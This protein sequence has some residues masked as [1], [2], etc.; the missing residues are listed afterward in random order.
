MSMNV[1]AYDTSKDNQLIR[2]EYRGNVYQFPKKIAEKYKVIGTK[3]SSKEVFSKLNA[4]YTKPSALLQGIRVRE[5]LTQVQLA[6]MIKVTQSDISQME[7][8][9]R[10]IGRKIAQRIESLFDVDYRSFLD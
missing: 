5:N 10:K 4:K 9:T 8:G 3:V 6:E 7:K 2:I 1:R